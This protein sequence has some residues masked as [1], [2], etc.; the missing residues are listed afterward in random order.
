MYTQAGSA[1][2]EQCLFAAALGARCVGYEI[3]CGIYIYIYI[4]YVSHDRILYHSMLYY[5]IVYY[6]VWVATP[7][8]FEC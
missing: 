2:G 8:G 4:M 6:V 3:L 7:C 1:L 5:M